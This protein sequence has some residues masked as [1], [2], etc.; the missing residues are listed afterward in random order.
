MDTRIMFYHC[1]DFKSAI[2]MIIP[3]WTIHICSAL[4][5]YFG[6]NCS[7]VQAESLP[8][9]EIHKNNNR[10]R[11]L[12]QT[13]SRSHVLQMAGRWKSVLWESSPSGVEQGVIQA[14]AAQEVHRCPPFVLRIAS[15]FLCVHWFCVCLFFFSREASRFEF[16]KLHI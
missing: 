3:T 15:L 12:W 7:A 16:R 6:Y 11:C 9:K 13:F 4:Q 5:L 10:W 1:H 14:A 2:K 8:K